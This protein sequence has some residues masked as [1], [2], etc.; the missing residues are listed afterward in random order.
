[1]GKYPYYDPA[2]IGVKFDELCAFF[3]TLNKNDVVLLHPCCHNPTGVDLTNEQ[4]D[5]VLQIIKDKQNHPLYG[6]RLSRLW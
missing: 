4:W 2:T 1:M 6:H 5:T 3:N